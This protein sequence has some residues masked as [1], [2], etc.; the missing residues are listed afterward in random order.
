MYSSAFRT[1]NDVE[2][3]GRTF[4]IPNKQ[5]QVFVGPTT[6]PKEV[7]TKIWQVK[8]LMIRLSASTNTFFVSS[9]HICLWFRTQ[10]WIG[11]SLLQ[12]IA[13]RDAT[14]AFECCFRVVFPILGRGWLL[15]YFQLVWQYVIIKI[16]HKSKPLRQAGNTPMYPQCWSLQWHQILFPHTVYY[17]PI[18]TV[19]YLRNFA[20][21]RMSDEY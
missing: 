8:V 5:R 3:F 12:L 19:Y 4:N 13:G 15:L 1:F 14:F 10:I 7:R 20:Y 2:I 9:S 11:A 16:H 21:E 6:D 18:H 17:F